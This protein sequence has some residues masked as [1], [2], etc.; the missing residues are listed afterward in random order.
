MNAIATASLAT[1]LASMNPQVEAAVISASA[2]I[3]GLAGTTAVGFFGFR[4]ARWVAGAT[5][6]GQRQRDVD[7]RRFAVYEDAVKYLLRLTRLRPQNYNFWPEISGFPAE[8]EVPAEEQAEVD[9]RIVAWASDE[10]RTLWE[11][12]RDGDHA[13]DVGRQHLAIL[14]GKTDLVP[15]SP[16][17][18]DYLEQTRDKINTSTHEAHRR[19]QATIEAIRKEL[20]GSQPS[21]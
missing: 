4:H 20:I 14:S 13:V 7:E 6:D 19:R 10:I 21:K 1:W 17:S 12:M 3:V 18:P 9:A 16:P 5:L 2:T 11:E 15:A 8:P